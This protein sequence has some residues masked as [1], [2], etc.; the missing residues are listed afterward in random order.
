MWKTSFLALSL[1][2]INACS[3]GFT[4]LKNPWEKQGVKTVYVPMFQNK[5]IEGGAEVP[6][7]KYLR[8]YIESRSSKL[9][10]ANNSGDAYIDGEVTSIKL[11]PGS[12]QYGTADTEK[13]G[14]L[15]N[16]RLLAVSYTVTIK[17]TLKLVRVSDKK[18]LW[19]NS[20]SQ[21]ASMSSGTYTNILSSSD[22]FI[23][24]TE[25]RKAIDTLA[26]TMMLFAVDSLLAEF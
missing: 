14:G 4:S 13:A 18:E 17:V 22:V 23:K 12:I 19:K 1:V 15:P 7:T 16:Q 2:L 3:Y 24:E 11:T 8:F 10:L 20:F 26:D 9:E 6:F 21:S 5:T 25:K